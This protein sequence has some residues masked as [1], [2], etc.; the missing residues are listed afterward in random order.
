MP[1]DLDEAKLKT[2]FEDAVSG[3]KGA[4]VESA[5][6][7]EGTGT[8]TEINILYDGLPVFKAVFLSSGKPR[9]AIILDDW[10]YSD[11][12]FHFFPEIKQ[13][14]TIAV[15]PGHSFSRK[16]A[17]LAR[18]WKKD[19]ILHLP[20]QPI[21]KMPMEKS[22]I[23]A[24]MSKEQIGA[25][26]ASDLESIGGA[27]GANNHEGSLVT[28]DR[29]IMDNLME[30][31]AARKMFF[32]DSV[33]N[34]RTVACT[35]ARDHGVASAQRDIFIDNIKELKYVEAQIELLEKAARRKGFAIGIGHDNPVTLEALGKKLPQLEG[36]G[37]EIV[38]VR[39]LVK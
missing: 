39:E 16:A 22:T 8:K 3:C 6:T 36:D 37:F 26:F 18:N 29:G 23:L 33:T 31:F 20:M 9:I 1:F 2:V 12:N 13:P 24:G 17:D 4:A 15:L 11:R 19:V 25:I 30:F 38:Y 10:G 7:K 34:G 5:E 27:L 21:K 35:S 32:V 28:A 14:F